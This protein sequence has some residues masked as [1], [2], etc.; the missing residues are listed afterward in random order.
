MRAARTPA[1][2]NA[3]LS[4]LALSVAGLSFAGSAWSEDV[5]MPSGAAAE[6]ATPA[7]APV[8]VPAR[9][10]TMN[11]VEAQL[12]APTE[13]H[14]AIGNPPITRWDYPGLSVFFEYS[15]VIHSVVR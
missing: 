12:G 6:T 14:A 3:R 4:L 7:P 5:A 15:H 8:N 1:R 2:K 9:G 10:A 13:R 11:K